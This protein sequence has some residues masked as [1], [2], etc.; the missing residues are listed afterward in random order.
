MRIKIS[1]IALALLF[2]MNAAAQD[3]RPKIAIKTLENPPDFPGSNIGNGLTD[4]LTTELQNTGKFNVLERS[5]VDELMK[6]I[7]FGSTEW[8]KNPTFAQKGQML[9]AQYILMGKVTNFG[10]T[11][12]RETRQKFQLLGPNIAQTIY[13]QQADVRVDFRLIDVSTGQTVISQWGEAHKTGGSETSEEARFLRV[14]KSNSMTTE[15]T[16]SLIGKTTTEAVK[17]VV[18]KLNALSATVREASHQ[19]S[20]SQVVERLA[21]AQ[22]MV[23]G[24]EGG[25]L[26]IVGLGSDAGLVKGDRLKLTHEN[27]VRD[28]KGNILY[29]KAIE[30]GT[31]E[32]TD[33]S[34]GDRSEARFVPASADG[35]SLPKPQ[36]NDTVKVDVEYA[37]A[38][39]GGGMPSSVSSA[40]APPVTS[41]AIAPAASTEAFL[42]RADGYLEGRFWSQALYE[43][44]K[45]AAATAPNDPRVLLGIS[46]ARYMLK[47]F[48]EAN[49]TADKL[50]QTGSPLKIPVAHNH[51][52]GFCT[53]ELLIQKGQLSFKPHK[54]DHA[55]EVVA[56]GL[57]GVEIGLLP[58]SVW[59]SSPHEGRSNIPVFVI[60][61]RD[62]SGHEKKYDMLPVIYMKNQDVNATR[63]DK[64]FPMDDGDISDLGTFE[65][66][67][68]DFIQRYVK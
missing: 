16:S 34:M 18:R 36:E 9:G 61:W 8:A 44:N 65:K 19:A 54:P 60:R 41:S 39:R 33:I 47:D 17:D 67:M 12:H 4:I 32:I 51:S 3:N 26:W 14:T 37:R 45:A 52:F 56:S 63:L 46:T 29:K 59:T 2:C 20:L 57:V 28:K 6:E 64:A 23:L 21:S 62:T 31:M 38:L 55:F 13:Q 66:A 11:E 43:Y 58:R 30:I 7:N 53:G 49:E 35:S 22:G 50:L 68:I 42:K 48:T 27:I 5:S 24:D 15:L 1:I 25:G 10:Y 40:S